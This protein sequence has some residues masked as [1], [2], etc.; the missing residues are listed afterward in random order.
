MSDKP[1]ALD[2]Y[3]CMAEAYAA[4]VDTK[5]HNAFYDRPA[6]ISLLPPVM[7]KRVLDAGCGPGVYSEWLVDHGAEV[8]GVDVSPKMVELANRRLNGRAKI[9]QADLN[10]PLAFI[11]AS[12]FDVIVSALAL[13]YIENWS[14]PFVEFFRI[15]REQGLLVF[16]VS[17]PF[18]EF[19]DHH[20]GGN[21]FETEQV[22]MNWNWTGTPLPVPYFRRPLDAMI[23]PLLGAGFILDR[24]LEPKPIPEF[25]KQDRR[26]YDKLMRQPG[27]ICFRARKGYS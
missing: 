24:L 26:D 23:D 20:P 18:D 16:S 25:K 10:E 9:I 2:A 3:E 5:P 11:E 27:F 17:H 15:L 4:R 21:Y 1:L 6:V 13:D 14:V 22:S 8:V 12:S 19:F 7:G